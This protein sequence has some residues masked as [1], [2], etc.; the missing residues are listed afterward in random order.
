M[1]GRAVAFVR[2]GVSERWLSLLR[3]RAPVRP[4]RIVP[5]PNMVDD[6]MASG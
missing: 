1:R 5:M 6:M 2:D 4:A 3:L